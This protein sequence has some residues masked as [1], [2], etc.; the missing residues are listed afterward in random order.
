MDLQP[1]S[2]TQCSSQTASAGSLLEWYC[3]ATFAPVAGLFFMKL[4]PK[5]GRALLVLLG[6]LKEEKPPPWTEQ[7]S[8]SQELN[9]ISLTSP[10]IDTQGGQSVG[11]LKIILK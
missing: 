3:W 7:T 2:D 11:A 9:F 4:L 1:K 6:W 8:S 10:Q 5:V